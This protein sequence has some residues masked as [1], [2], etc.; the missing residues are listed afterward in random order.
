LIHYSMKPQTVWAGQGFGEI[1]A[2]YP[3]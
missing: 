1:P 3:T 2:E